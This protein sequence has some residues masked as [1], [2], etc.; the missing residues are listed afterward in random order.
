MRRVLVL[1]TA[2]VLGAGCSAETP[3]A[4]PVSSVGAGASPSAPATSIPTPTAPAG[5]VDL[6]AQ[7]CTDASQAIAEASAYFTAQM[8]ALEKA[9]AKGDQDAVVAAATAIQNRITALGLAVTTFTTQTISPE[10][11]KVLVESAASL[12]EIASE[13]YTGTQ[14]DIRKTFTQL[15][16]AFDKACR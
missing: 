3:P 13:A 1:A 10:L 4:E 5:G 9:A 7:V 14:A 2:L 12:Q 16:G 15:T 11:R 6:T 8:S